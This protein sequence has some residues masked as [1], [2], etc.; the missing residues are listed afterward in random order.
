MLPEHFA[1]ALLRTSLRKWQYTPARGK[2]KK[3]KKPNKT[4][5]TPPLLVFKSNITILATTAQL[6]LLSCWSFMPLLVICL[7]HKL[8]WM[9]Q[10][11]STITQILLLCHQIW[12]LIKFLLQ[13]LGLVSSL[14]L[15]TRHCSYILLSSLITIVRNPKVS[16]FT[17]YPRHCILSSVLSVEN[18]FLMKLYWLHVT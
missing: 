7:W 6:S 5:K 1:R 14:S 11:N 16:F 4:P 8:S 13:T 9:M 15:V 12:E 10:R 2:K 18:V 3:H 17:L